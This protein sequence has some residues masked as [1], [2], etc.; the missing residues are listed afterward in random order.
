MSEKTDNSYYDMEADITNM[1]CETQ[2]YLFSYLAKKK[3]DMYDFIDKY[4][5]SSFVSREMDAYCAHNQFADPE[6]ILPDI[7]NEIKIIFDPLAEEISPDYA[8]SL[9]YIYRYVS[10][11]NNIPS[12]ALYDKVGPKK[13][14]ALLKEYPDAQYE[15]FYPWVYDIYKEN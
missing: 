5:H 7:R 3:C 14:L 13:I 10:R 2:A 8:F 6:E 12:S 1:I 9:G 4:M 11:T 15:D